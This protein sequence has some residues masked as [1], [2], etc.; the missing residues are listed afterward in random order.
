MPE[1]REV[2]LD[3]VPLTPA[4]ATALAS[5]PHVE[6]VQL[7]SATSLEE[8]LEGVWPPLAELGERLLSLNLNVSMGMLPL[9]AEVAGHQLPPG[10]LAL[11]G[12][13][14][15]DMLLM[16]HD[17][18]LMGHGALSRM[19]LPGLDRLPLHTLQTDRGTPAEVWRCSQLTQLSALND[20]IAM[21]A[22][23]QGGLPP[24]L[25]LD[26]TYWRPASHGFPTALRGLSR[27]E[28]LSL[29]SCRFPPGTGLPAEFSQLRWGLWC[30]RLVACCC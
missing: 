15:L 9:A 22:A 5:R 8:L 14:R 16:G 2:V 23:G 25:S 6:A 21:P 19:H 28:T 3:G 29:H 10:L 18:L 7:G 1:L 4:L 17:M 13:G 20:P 26:L 27:L 30:T 12:L 11:T 24:L